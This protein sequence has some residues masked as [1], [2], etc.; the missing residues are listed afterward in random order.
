MNVEALAAADPDLILVD[1]YE[2]N[3]VVESAR[4]IAPT[5]QMQSF[6]GPR[7]LISSFGRVFGEARAEELNAR[8]DDGVE[9]LRSLVEAP[10][11]IRVSIAQ[12]SEEGIRIWL[13]EG[14]LGAILISEAG[15]SRPSSQSEVG[16]FGSG[17]KDLSL[18]R[19]DAV[20]GDV[21]YLARYADD[22]AAYEELTSQEL[23]KSLEVVRRDAVLSVDYRAWNLGGPLAADVVFDDIARGLRK[24]GLT[25]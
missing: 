1:F 10:S 2:G 5:L 17:Y 21:L 23:W 12:V 25:K 6:A 24:A 11:S 4:E 3:P 18:E 20:D 22:D 14:N 9:R 15:F 16:E 13:A 8:L 7:E 19:L